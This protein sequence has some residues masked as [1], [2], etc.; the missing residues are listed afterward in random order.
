MQIPWIYVG[1][2]YGATLPMGLGAQ[3]RYHVLGERPTTPMEWLSLYVPSSRD[4]MVTSAT[5][6]APFVGSMILPGYTS[7]LTP[8]IPPL[9]MAAATAVGTATMMDMV[10]DAIAD[11]AANLFTPYQTGRDA[12]PF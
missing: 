2:T 8:A 1:H 7:I 10:S 11:F 4:Q 6:S 9:A 5:M 3:Y 12:N